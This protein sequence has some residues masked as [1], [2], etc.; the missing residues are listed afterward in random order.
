MQDFRGV[1]RRLHFPDDPRA[2]AVEHC[3]VPLFDAPE[4]DLIERALDAIRTS[5]GNDV[6]GRQVGIRSAARVRS[7]PERVRTRECCAPDISF[8]VC[9]RP[10][11]PHLKE[12]DRR[13]WFLWQKAGLAGGTRWFSFSR[14][15][16]SAGTAPPGGGT[17]PGR[18]DIEGPDGRVSRPR[19]RP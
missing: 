9:A 15:P 7:G 12:A 3:A 8:A 10:R 5:G 1:G 6:P 13:F 11:R 19:S 2:Y 18:A 16:S 4:I 14:R 17:G